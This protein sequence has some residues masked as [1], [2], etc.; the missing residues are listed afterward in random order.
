MTQAA[1]GVKL[2]D[3]TLGGISQSQK[4][5]LCDSACTGPSR[6]HMQKK[7]VGAGCQGQRG[8]GGE[9][10]DGQTA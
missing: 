9:L 5:K 8:R 3:I 2:E 6:S 10:L 4:D 1:T 7:K